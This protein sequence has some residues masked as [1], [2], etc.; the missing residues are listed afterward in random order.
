M[1]VRKFSFLA[2]LLILIL[3]S[4]AVAAQ[5]YSISTLKQPINVPPSAPGISPYRTPPQQQTPK[6]AA[7][8][9]PSAPPAQ[10]VTTS[11]VMKRLLVSVVV[12]DPSDVKSLTSLGPV[13]RV[14]RLKTGEYVA[15]VITTPD[16]IST[17]K[18][19]KTNRA[20][21]DFRVKPK[22]YVPN[23]TRLFSGLS[24]DE[25]KK[26]VPDMIAVRQVIRADIV[27]STLGINGT[28]VTVAVVDTGVDYSNPDLRNALEYYVGQYYQPLDGAYVTVREPLVLDADEAQVLLMTSVAP[29]ATGYLNL[30]GVSVT[31]LLP[32]PETLTVDNTTK[33]TTAYVGGIPS[34]SGTYKF[35]ITDVLIIDYYGN[36]YEYKYNVLM[37]DPNSPGNYTLVIIDW[38]NNS[39]FTDE[40]LSGLYY[41]YD[42]DRITY[43]D[44]NADGLYDAGDVSLGVIGGFFYDCYW[45]FN[46][47]GM[48]YPGWDLKGRYLSF[49]YDFMGHGTQCA[50][51]I[52]SRGLWSGLP[53]VAP[54]AKVMGIKGLWMGCVEPGM[55]WAAGFDIDPSTGAFYY[56]G[57][58]RA[59]VISNSWGLSLQFYDEFGFG[60][61][62]ESMFENGLVSPGFLDPNFPGIIIVHA[63]GNGGPGYSTITS[64]GAASGVLTVGAST[65]FSTVWGGVFSDDI[66]SWSARAPTPVGEAK[67]DVVDVGAFGWTVAPIY[68]GGIDLFGGTSMATPVTAGVVAL[69]LQANPSLKSKPA[70]VRSIIQSS[71][72]DLK[73]NPFIQGSGRVDA[74]NAVSL[75]LRLAGTEPGTDST[76]LVTTS[77]SQEYLSKVLSGAWSVQWFYSIPTTFYSYWYGNWIYPAYSGIPDFAD[78]SGSLYLGIMKAGTSRTFSIQVQNPMPNSLS[79]T[80]RAVKYMIASAPYNYRGVLTS[81]SNYDPSLPGGFGPFYY[82]MV[83]DPSQFTKAD[84]TKFSM[85]FDYSK[86]DYNNDYSYDAIARLWILYWNGTGTPTPL[87]NAFPIDY[88]YNRGTTQE[89]LIHDIADRVAALGSNY[90][91]VVWVGIQNLTD[92]DNIPF[93]LRITNYNRVTD[94]SVKLKTSSGTVP[95]GGTAVI[96]GTVTASRIPGP[97]EGY[98]EID[99]G[100]FKRYIPYTYGSALP[101]YYIQRLTVTP[102]TD[103]LLYNPSTLNGAFDWSWRYESGD[104]RIYY[105]ELENPGTK[106]LLVDFKWTQD[107]STLAIYTLNSIGMFAGGYFGTGVSEHIPV[108]GSYWDPIY[109]IESITDSQGNWKKEMIATPEVNTFDYSV[110]Y[111]QTGRGY[112][113]IMVHQLVNGGK[114]IYEPISGYVKV[115]TPYNI[116]MY[117]PP[118]NMTVESGKIVPT[119]F[120]WK[121]WAKA[122]PTYYGNSTEVYTAYTL[123]LSIVPGIWNTTKVYPAGYIFS[124]YKDAGMMINT[125]GAGAGEYLAGVTYVFYHPDYRLFY[126]YGGAAYEDPYISTIWFAED[127]CP[128]YVPS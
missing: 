106:G 105:V 112:Y 7:S 32:W 37:A 57:A 83:I 18:R 13:S 47:P 89:V 16:K 97:H 93:V 15:L 80:A 3:P 52:A 98:I 75:A 38:N 33:N 87:T 39:D 2:L 108:T 114:M 120:E 100:S 29:N 103:A 88:S 19:L 22:P 30:T 102:P 4:L 111:Q 74:L 107:N 62:L 23:V 125:T 101:L 5:P 85:A 35:G 61:D 121:L 48:F 118:C 90:K 95:A 6:V 110:A 86:F 84:L 92:M 70:L 28:G 17:L 10:P 21:L 43:Y 24:K 117:I 20:I 63:A 45:N 34:A 9:V 46:F 109:Y 60:Y 25:L 122:E 26:I 73:Y 51:T 8:V 115:L 14:V 31:T 27:N 68:Y 77:S 56:T 64:P 65:S 116:H 96:D 82:Y 81:A 113:T 124:T 67:P 42:G 11:N 36:V 126:K 49:F 41:T 91:I 123:P 104:W 66:I 53:G 58:P 99:F 119:P 72:V 40:Y 1:D 128:V 55:L 59:D 71:T 78:P 50:G 44:A 79:F 12:K 127:W 76:V 94:S 69:V 54:G